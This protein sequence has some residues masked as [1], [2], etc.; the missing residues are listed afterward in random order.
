MSVGPHSACAPVEA[1]DILTGVGRVIVV[2]NLAWGEGENIT[3]E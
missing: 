1:R 3:A 2:Q